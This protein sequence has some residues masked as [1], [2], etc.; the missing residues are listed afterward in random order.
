MRKWREWTLIQK[1][2]LEWY[3]D[4]LDSLNG[5][6]QSY[7]VVLIETRE[8]CDKLKKRV[9]EWRKRYEEEAERRI[10]LVQAMA[11]EQWK[12]V[13]ERQSAETLL[14]WGEVV[15]AQMPEHEREKIRA[16]EWAV[17]KKKEEEGAK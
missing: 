3:K 1:S 17:E 16:I 15:I 10:E 14:K 6:V 2:K 12:R 11:D 13:I 4:E 8:K 7:S 9:E 5:R